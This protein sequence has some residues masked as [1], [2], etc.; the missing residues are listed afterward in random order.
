MKAPKIDLIVVDEATLHQVSKETTWEEV[1]KLNLIPRLRE[2]T[3]NAWI[4][5]HGL[6]AIQIGIPLRF[7]LFRWG[8]QEFALMNPEIIS[9]HGKFK[10]LEE[11]CLSIPK[12]RF[13][14]KRHYKIKYINDGVQKIAKGLKSQIIQHEIDHMNGIILTDK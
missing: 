6:A 3:K 10:N 7:A 2:A 4:N 5:G 11:G 13:K 14:L 9:T 8:Y 1:E 12:K